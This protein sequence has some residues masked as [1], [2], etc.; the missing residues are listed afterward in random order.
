MYRCVFYKCRKEYDTPQET[1]PACGCKVVAPVCN[2]C[3]DSNFAR[4]GGWC[5]TCR[6]GD[7][8]YH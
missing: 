3:G 1:C 2:A 4:N 7:K 5:I 6:Y 8:P